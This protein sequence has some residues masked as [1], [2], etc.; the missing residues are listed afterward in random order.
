M[1]KISIDDLGLEKLVA[2]GY[3]LWKT[4]SPFQHKAVLIGYQSEWWHNS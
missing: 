4:S 3:Q 1:K 2:N